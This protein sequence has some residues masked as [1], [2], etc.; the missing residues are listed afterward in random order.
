MMPSFQ[1]LSS[2]ST[3]VGTNNL[4]ERD[5]DGFS[6]QAR[7]AGA[8]PS[9]E[10]IEK[11]WPV[12]SA[13]ERRAGKQSLSQLFSNSRHKLCQQRALLQLGQQ[14]EAVIQQSHREE[15]YHQ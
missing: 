6:G 12:R 14:T 15:N 4:S 1:L 7:S 5:G 9:E 10:S 8:R 3:E 11:Q 2:S 13:G